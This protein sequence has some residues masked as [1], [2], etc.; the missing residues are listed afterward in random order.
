MKLPIAT[1]I[2]AVVLPAAAAPAPSV[3]VMAD[4]PYLEA[5]RAEKL[6]I[7]LP[8]SGGDGSAL[9]PAVVYF[10]GGGWYKGDKATAR[11]KNIGSNLAAAGYVF[12]S[13]NYTLGQNVW[14][15]NLDD[16]KNAVRFLRAHAADYRV[17]PDRIA[18]MGASAG[19]HLALLVAFTAGDKSLEPAGPYPGVSDQVRAVIDFYGMTNLLTRQNVTATGEPTGKLDDAHSAEML[20]VS[21]AAGAV[22]WKTASPVTHI[23]PDSPPVLIAH[24]LSDR[25]VDYPQAVELA[26]VLRAAGVPHELMLLEGVGHMFDLET[27][28]EKPLPRDIRPGVLDF[29]A[30][31][32]KSP[33]KESGK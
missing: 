4:V 16:C 1:V 32:L 27:W 2:L 19:G 3:R 31:Y 10:H 5:T 9:R 33:G 23:R 8:A 18:V 15:R 11:E 30:R 17:D 20:G 13:A 14:P 24:G 7:Y 26:N 21:R 25:T 29:L 6:D 28:E 22:L 12:V